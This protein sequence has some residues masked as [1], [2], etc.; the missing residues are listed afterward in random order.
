MT[1]SVH[2]EKQEGT[3]LIADA[4][5]I[6]SLDISSVTK[7]EFVSLTQNMDMI[8]ENMG[9]SDKPVAK[10]KLP[11]LTL[12]QTQIINAVEDKLAEG[13]NNFGETVGDSGTYRRL[14][15]AAFTIGDIDDA[16]KYFEKALQIDETSDDL[17]GIIED[18][19]WIGHVLRLRGESEKALD[20]LRRSLTFSEEL[21]DRQGMA[22]SLTAIG[23]VYRERGEPNK[24]LGYYKRSLAICEEIGDKETMA[25][26]IN[27][28]GGT[29][30]DRGEKDKAQKYYK[31]SLAL[32]EE[33]EDK[34][35][36]ATAYNN[37]GY[38]F[39]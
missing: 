19:Q 9:I 1:G 32:Y 15:S 2:I 14:G 18:Y 29:Y 34:E 22:D 11:E 4:I 37:I 31:R 3:V 8:L 24:A 38:S 39:I 5:T 6:Q 36:M 10:E 16:H 35:G 28:I 13:E 21:G 23:L 26:T 27:N 20:Y 33:L 7:E 30:D 25:N 12:E 17:S